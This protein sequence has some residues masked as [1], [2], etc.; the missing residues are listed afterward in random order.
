MARS[1]WD[2]SAVMASLPSF[3]STA[4]PDTRN[5]TI[6]FLDCK[7]DLRLTALN[8]AIQTVT[9]F[10]KLHNGEGEMR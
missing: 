8:Q 6:L 9:H 1:S 7:L 4:G 10:G 2:A 5:S 3:K